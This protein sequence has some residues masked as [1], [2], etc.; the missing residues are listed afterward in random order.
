MPCRVATPARGSSPI[1]AVEYARRSIPAEVRPSFVEMETSLRRDAKI[2]VI[3][4]MDASANREG[5]DV[6]L[7]TA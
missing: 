5:E 6:A 7:R 2:P 3:P 1:L 4:K